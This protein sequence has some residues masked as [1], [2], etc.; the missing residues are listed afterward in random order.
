MENP[1]APVVI[2]VEPHFGQQSFD[3]SKEIGSGY[4]K[5]MSLSLI[6]CQIPLKGV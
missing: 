1:L 6:Y 5:A 4:S 3:L 2:A